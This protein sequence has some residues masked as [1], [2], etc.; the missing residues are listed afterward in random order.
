MTQPL[1]TGLEL[2][3]VLSARA[4]GGLPDEVG[5]ASI[6]TR[7]LMPGDLFFAIKG[8]ARDGHDFVADALANGAAAAVVDEAHAGELKHLGPLFVVDDVLAAMMAAGR[9]A[10]ARSEAR[11]V[12]VTGSAGKTG[13]K[14]ALRLALGRQGRT[15]AS[16]ASYNNHWGVPL[17]LARMPRDCAYG[18]FEIGMNAPGEILPLTRQVRPQVAIV[19]TVEPVHLAFF[20]SVAAI[21]DAKGEVF[22]GLE[23]GGTAILNRD[24]PQFER[25]KAHAAASPAGRV[26]SFGVHEEA[27]VRAQR[28]I[29]QPDLSIVEAR[30]FGL[31]VTY[32]LGSPGRHIA[33]NSLS[34]LAAVHVL[35]A[36]LAIAALSLGQLE[37][38]VGRGERTRLSLAG[39]DI[40]LIDESFNANPASMRAALA[41][42]GQT[43]PGHRGR[44]IAVLADMLELGQEGP[45]LHRDLAEAVEENGIDLIFAA[46]PLMRELWQA[47][48]GERRGGYAGTAADLEPMVIEALR[49]GDAVMVKGSKATKVSR[50]VATLKDRFPAASRPLEASA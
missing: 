7:T 33:L 15:H 21:A 14:E 35:G 18:I 26:V 27:D 28:I 16:V 30:V 2:L 4:H 34:V 8:E 41:N 45:A 12:A 38:P 39:G 6:D 23:P 25:L 36:D 40:V 17:T 47:L 49:G 31:P 48:P 44:R 22:Q 43:A 13:T 3:T 10:R 37:A 1:W 24:N 32:R 5:G 42:L 9:A 20:P 46:G 29:T 11:I 19:T 50:I